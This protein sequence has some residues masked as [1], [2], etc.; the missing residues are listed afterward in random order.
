[1]I[2][3]MYFITNWLL[4][5][6]AIR[7]KVAWHKA[8]RGRAVDYMGC[9]VW[10]DLRNWRV[11]LTVNE[12]FRE[13]LLAELGTEAAEELRLSLVE[14][15]QSALTCFDHN[16]LKSTNFSASRPSWNAE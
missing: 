10:A 7:V 6:L 8:A 9:S 16:F 5:L 3:C 4:I 12:K 13:E 14:V 15:R 2:L 1:M 11:V